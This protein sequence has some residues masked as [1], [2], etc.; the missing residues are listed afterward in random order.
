MPDE[1]EVAVVVPGVGYS[2]SLPAFALSF[3]PVP[4]IPAVLDG[5]IVL[6]A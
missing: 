4:T 6:V 1:I 2:P 3:V 5:V